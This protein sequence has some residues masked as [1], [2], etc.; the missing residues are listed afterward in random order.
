MRV[1][2][3][4]PSL[5]TWPYD[6]AL[7]LALRAEGH[8]VT[9]VGKPLAK[10]GAGPAHDLLWPYFYRRL[11]P[12]PTR[13]LSKALFLARKGVSHAL[14]MRTLARELGPWRPDVIH[15][16]WAPL[17][18]V[19]RLFLAAVRELAPIVFTVHD[20]T[21][22]NGNPRSFIQAAGAL[23][24]LSRF[25][26]L[27]VHT[28][29]AVSRLRT[30]GVPD[31][32]VRCVPHGPLDAT[33]SERASAQARAIDP[34]P[35]ARASG[36][37]VQVLLFG[38]IKPYKGADVL[39][40]AAALMDPAIRKRCR[41]RIVGEPYIDLAPLELAIREANMAD[42]VRIEPRFVAE[43]DVDALLASA[44]ILVF[45]Y[46]QIDASGVLMKSLALGVPI[47]ATGIGLFAEMLVDGRH[48]RLVAADDPASLAR[49][50]EQ[51]VC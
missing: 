23:G 12:N 25:D 30:Y 7:A 41:I 33:T 34:Q 26:R 19:D 32:L 9:I 40:R 1:A 27:I 15:F 42:Q 28:Q 20:S 47:V 36:A 3:I 31:E 51:L 49:A 39:V 44:D 48:G 13:G 35:D 50:L 11:R 38:K 5:F 22:F 21:P 24:I 4:D 29:Q 17:P 16:Q 14:S 2:L 18:M 46:R 43:Q 45:P 10:A 6:S 37:P 8:D